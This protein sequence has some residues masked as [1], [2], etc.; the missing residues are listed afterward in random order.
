MRNYRRNSKRILAMLLGALSS[1]CLNINAAENNNVR[2]K[3]NPNRPN[4]VNEGQPVSFLKKLL[5]LCIAGGATLATYKVARYVIRHKLYEG[6]KELRGKDLTRLLYLA[7]DLYRKDKNLCGISEDCIKTTYKK[8]DNGKKSITVY[9]VSLT[10]IEGHQPTG[11]DLIVFGPNCYT[12]VLLFNPRMLDNYDHVYLVDRSGYG[13]ADDIDV[14]E[15]MEDLYEGARYF[16]N[17]ILPKNE[18]GRKRELLCFSMGGAETSSLMELDEYK[19]FTLLSPACLKSYCDDSLLSKALRSVFYDLDVS[20]AINMIEALE[21]RKSA[22][23]VHVI[24]GDK[25]D[26]LCA[27]K[28]LRYAAIER[29]G[30]T[31]PEDW[32][33]LTLQQQ[34]NR[35]CE[36]YQNKYPGKLYI[37]VTIYENV[38]HEGNAL[39]YQGLHQLMDNSTPG[40]DTPAPKA[41]KNTF[42]DYMIMACE[43]NDMKIPKL[44]E[45]LNDMKNASMNWA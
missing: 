37:D 35:L 10:S 24:S 1:S 34:A 11:K 36:F 25:K 3:R 12:S 38:N 14:P 13:M 39:L 20:W 22:M 17:E 21:K 9:D 40:D 41:N 8:Y 31:D 29:L 4:T 28:S 7:T 23:H 44:K 15:N 33:T 5:L 43:V 16:V 18:N 42:L 6:T 26:K 45:L 30:W 2:V 19:Y 32:D 27:V